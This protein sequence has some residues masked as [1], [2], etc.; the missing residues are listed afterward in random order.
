MR[1]IDGD[2]GNRRGFSKVVGSFRLLP[3]LLWSRSRCSGIRGH[4]ALGRI[5]IWTKG[6][7]IYFVSVGLR[8]FLQR[9][10]RWSPTTKFQDFKL[11]ATRTTIKCAVISIELT[12]MHVFK[13]FPNNIKNRSSPNINRHMNAQT[14]APVHIETVMKYFASRRKNK[15]AERMST[16]IITP[17]TPVE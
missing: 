15:G 4:L 17:P 11:F 5:Q 9:I 3:Q 16:G 2:F 6:C 12:Q 13:F 1:T 8:K 10:R 7:S 14:P